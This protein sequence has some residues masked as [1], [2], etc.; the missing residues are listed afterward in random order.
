MSDDITMPPESS[1][2]E[3]G[4]L[5]PPQSSPRKRP[6]SWKKFAIVATLWLLFALCYLAHPPAADRA[7][8]FYN[9]WLQLNGLCTFAAL[10]LDIAQKKL[11]VPAA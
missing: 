10:G 6:A 8:E 1:P 2:A 7:Y 5:T 4:V 11:A 3:R 9:T